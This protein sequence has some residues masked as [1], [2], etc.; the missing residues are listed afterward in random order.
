MRYLRSQD[1]IVFINK[2][3]PTEFFVSKYSCI[4]LNNT[5]TQPAIFC[6][7]QHE[8]G[9]IHG[10]PV[11]DGWA[12]AVTRKS[13]GI[14]KCDGWTDR[15]TNLPTYQPTRQGEESRVRD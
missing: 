5:S 4:F 13:L 8:Q 11:A 12:G 15:Q 2:F 3:V 7:C 1:K 6:Y 9:Q 14:Q 10:N